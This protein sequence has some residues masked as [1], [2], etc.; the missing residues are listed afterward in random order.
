MSMSTQ[1]FL[2]FIIG[3]G[4]FTDVN[5]DFLCLVRKKMCLFW[6][7]LKTI[8][9]EPFQYSIWLFFQFL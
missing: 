8:F 2:T 9:G 6:E 5:F 3:N 4:Y 1:M 7:F